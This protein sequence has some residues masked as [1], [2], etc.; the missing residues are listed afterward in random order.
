MGEPDRRY[1]I[2]SKMVNDLE[3]IKADYMTEE[4]ITNQLRLEK[5][6]EHYFKFK[7]N[8]EY[9]FLDCE[10]CEGPILGHKTAACRHTEGYEEKTVSKFKKWLERNPEVRKLMKARAESEADR[11]T[12]TQAEIMGQ[13]LKDST[14]ARNTTQLVKARQPPGWTGQRF[15]KWQNEVVKWQMNNKSTEEDKFMDLVESLKKNEAIKD[16]VSKTLLEK[17]GETRTIEKILSVMAEKFSKTVCERVKETMKK[18]CVFQMSG[19]V[20]SLI[21]NFEEMLLEMSS[22]EMTTPR[23]EYAISAQFVDR[24]AASGKIDSTE[25]LR[26]KDILEESDGRPKR[27]NTTEL[28]KREL[29]RLKVAENREEPFAPFSNKDTI[30]NYVRTPCTLR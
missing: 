27:G 11:A 9:E 23:M 18:I 3:I 5:S 4:S 21:D 17:V 15:D 28:M 24:L 25:K 26:L 6:L 1:S 2:F 22:L 8:G 30:T 13:V 12:R 29:K 16:F 20:D 19:S 10:N 14:E 7:S